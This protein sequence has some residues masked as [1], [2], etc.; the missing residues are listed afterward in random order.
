MLK[1]YTSE[2]KYIDVE[3]KIA[4]NQDEL[5]D[6]LDDGATDIYLCGDRFSIP[7][8]KSG[9]SY[10]GINNPTVVVNSK[11]EVN[12]EEKKIS[13]SDVKFDEKYQQIINNIDTSTYKK[14]V[15]ISRNLV[16]AIF[17]SLESL[18]K[19]LE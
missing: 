18:N 9:I 10:H 3:E 19:I 12:W 7:L 4:F 14:E 1:E 15:E 11:E 16:R 13:L 17:E 2:Q 8:S 6:L 5:Y